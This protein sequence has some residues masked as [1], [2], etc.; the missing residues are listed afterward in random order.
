[1][2]H[3]KRQLLAQEEHRLA[4]A[5]LGE[6]AAQGIGVFCWCNRCFHSATLDSVVLAAELGPA[7]PVPE[8]G[9]RLRCSSCQ[10][11]DIATRPD[12]PGLGQVARAQPPD[13]PADTLPDARLDTPSCEPHNPHPRERT[14]ARGAQQAYDSADADD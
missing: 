14:G 8:L 5:Q 6:L 13:L 3:T 4:P 1:M 10:S 7:Y 11:K 9:A 12:W 2:S